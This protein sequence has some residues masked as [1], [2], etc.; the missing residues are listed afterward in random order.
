MTL[1]FSFFRSGC[2]HRNEF[3]IAQSTVSGNNNTCISC[4]SLF[5]CCDDDDDVI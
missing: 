2:V 4:I 3:C 1:V 5:A